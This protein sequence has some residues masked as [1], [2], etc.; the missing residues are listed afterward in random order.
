VDGV[1]VDASAVLAED[2]L[3]R[4]DPPNPDFDEE[5]TPPPQKLKRV[6]TA[7][8]PRDNGLSRGHPRRYR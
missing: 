7:L 8:A 4:D 2:P 5:T 3:L 6:F 1:R